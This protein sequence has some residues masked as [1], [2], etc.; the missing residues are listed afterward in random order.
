M[1]AQ[2]YVAIAAA[3]DQLL[4][5]PGAD[6]ERLAVPLLHLIKEHP[7]WLRQYAPP[8]HIPVAGTSRPPARALAATAGAALRALL[9]AVRQTLAGMA[10]AASGPPTR[11]LLVSHLTSPAQL[12]GRDDAYFGSLQQLLQARGIASTLVLIDHLRDAAARRECTAHPRLAQQQLLPRAV[13]L[14]TELKIWW[15]CL[16]ARRRLR[17]EARTA[18]DPWV[19]SIAALAARDIVQGQTLANLRVHET[20]ARICARLKPAIVIT[21]HEGDACERLIWHAA[22]T[23][24]RPPLCVGYQH[25]LLPQHAHAIRRCLGGPQGASDPDVILTLGRMSHAALAASPNLRGVRL[26][27][28]GSH[29]HARVRVHP[30]WSDRPRQ[31]LVLPDA[32]ESEC[33][34]LFGFALDCAQRC[35]EMTF[36]LR[37]HPIVEFAGLAHRHPTLRL[38]PPNVR[39]SSLA[40]VQDCVQAR[41]CLYRGSS[42]ALHAVLF[43]AKPF[44]LARLEELVFDPLFT[45]G[46]W[47]ETVNSPQE[48]V[49]RALRADAVPDPGA[50][51]RARDECDRYIC[52]VRPGA[53]DELLALAES[54]HRGEALNGE[55]RDRFA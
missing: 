1:T 7:S 14:A 9:R 36:V 29:R 15:R 44:Y 11:V 24:L 55:F 28:Y 23:L 27:E 6:L 31:C 52:A 4:Q 30:P 35:P 47:R 43:G 50:A 54:S 12:Q 51:Q 3:C 21:T 34:L 25:A 41:Y 20:L 2:E 45:L 22:R 26:I 48:F 8:A 39:I 38:L 16:R 49:H 17:R 33:V 40:L 32:E 19:R 18:T 5:A 42:A 10:G 46:E 13:P 53:I 37:P